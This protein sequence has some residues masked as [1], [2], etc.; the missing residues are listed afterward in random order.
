MNRE[1]ATTPRAALVA[2]DPARILASLHPRHDCVPRAQD[3]ATN[4]VFP[5]IPLQPAAVLVPMIERPEGMQ[6]L[7]T[8]RT[9]HLQHH[10]GQVSFPGGRVEAGDADAVATALRETEEE[11]GL[12][13]SE[14]RV[15]G[16][17]D[18]LRTLTGFDILP[19]VGFIRPG[20][21]LT[22]D[23]FEVAEAFEV[24]LAFLLDFAN[25]G[26]ERREVMGMALD[27]YVYHHGGQRIWGA[28]AR[29]LSDL[30]E[31]YHR[32]LGTGA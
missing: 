8:R 5:D 31:R 3:V 16:Y 14:V 18:R 30:A 23:A 27:F 32:Q 11:I 19:V 4:I 15:V 28:T 2:P 12:A 24:P 17:L 1:H 13:R 9:D 7:L 6:V 29:I 21:Q 20:F 10:P 26:I 22:L 25:R